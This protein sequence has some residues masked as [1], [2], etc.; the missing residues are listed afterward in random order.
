[1]R[2]SDLGAQRSPQA[3]ETPLRR[4][5]ART[6][7][8]RMRR[9]GPLELVSP[10][11][12]GQHPP[13]TSRL[14]R[15]EANATLSDPARPS[16]LGGFFRGWIVRAIRSLSYWTGLSRRYCK[17]ISTGPVRRSIGRGCSTGRARTRSSPCSWCVARNRL[18][19]R[20]TAGRSRFPRGPRTSRAARSA[21]QHARHSAV[22]IR[23]PFSN[24][25]IWVYQSHLL[26]MAT[27]VYQGLGASLV[28]ES[29]HLEIGWIQRRPWSRVS[30][31]ATDSTRPPGVPRT[32]ADHFEPPHANGM[33]KQHG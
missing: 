25:I 9:L 12:R 8:R 1:M 18:A 19:T 32:A 28:I 3:I 33:R 16:P 4:L 14:P 13:P 31:P 24:P 10:A 2:M 30:R 21:G 7:R 11:A 5:R 17:P 15:M 20:S 26:E 22:F 6:F 29:G 23:W 27:R